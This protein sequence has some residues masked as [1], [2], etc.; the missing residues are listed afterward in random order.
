MTQSRRPAP[1]PPPPPPPPFSPLLTVEPAEV[2]SFL[3]RPRTAIM[4]PLLMPGPG[5]RRRRPLPLPRA[6]GPPPRATPATS[7]LFSLTSRSTGMQGAPGCLAAHAKGGG[8]RGFAQGGGGVRGSCLSGAGAAARPPA[9]ARGHSG[10]AAARGAGGGAVQRR[11]AAA[12]GDV[13]C[14]RRRWVAC[15]SCG[16]ASGAPAAPHALEGPLRPGRGR[17]WGDAGGGVGP[18]RGG[19]KWGRLGGRVAAEGGEGRGRHSVAQLV[20]R[21]L[22]AKHLGIRFWLLSWWGRRARQ[23]GGPA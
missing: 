17:A 20:G 10:A 6:L 15:E 13:G 5:R 1:P 18:G 16:G 11:D 12:A 4:G 7:S 9:Q 14:A 8:A 23:R 21:L 3:H 19:T 22:A 2:A